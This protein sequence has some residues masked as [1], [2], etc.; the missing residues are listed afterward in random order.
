MTRYVEAYDEATAVAMAP[1][2][3]FSSVPQYSVHL[4]ATPVDFKLKLF[5]MDL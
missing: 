2:S 3:F 4:E 5:K 1:A